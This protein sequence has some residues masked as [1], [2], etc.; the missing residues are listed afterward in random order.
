MNVALR[1]IEGRFSEY[2]RRVEAG[3]EIVVTDRGRP[4]ARLVPARPVSGEEGA[5]REAEAI[6][7]LD[8]LPWIRPGRGGKPEGSKR[9]MAWKPGD[10]LLSEAIVEDR[11]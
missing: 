1:E 10:P 4:V 2:L 9:P 8:G 5:D 7:R 6:A 11:E 3:E